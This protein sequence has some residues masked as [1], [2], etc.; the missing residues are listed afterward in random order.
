[1]RGFG[2]LAVRIW[3]CAALGQFFALLAFFNGVDEVRSVETQRQL[4]TLL[5]RAV[6]PVS[7]MAALGFPLEYQSDLQFLVDAVTVEA[8]RT[9]DLFIL[10]PDGV[11]VFASDQGAIG[12]TAPAHWYGDGSAAASWTAQSRG[13]TVVGAAVVNAFG[14]PIGTVIA[15][16]SRDGAVMDVFGALRLSVVVS[17]VFLVLVGLVAWLGTSLATQPLAVRLR[18][19]EEGFRAATADLRMGIALEPEGDRGMMAATARAV[20]ALDAVEEACRGID[21]AVAG[22]AGHR[23]GAAGEPGVGSASPNGPERPARSRA[24]EEMRA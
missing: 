17:G 21:R 5:A 7:A 20:T 3:L 8:G 14:A 11:V 24:A 1:M 13:E 22:R 19:M 2:G 12:S 16:A 9:E 6:A 18:T 4:Q 10:N 23:A 15:R